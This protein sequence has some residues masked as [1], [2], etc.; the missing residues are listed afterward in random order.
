MQ[1][2][3]DLESMK[4]F[5][6]NRLKYTYKLDDFAAIHVS[7]VKTLSPTDEFTFPNF[8]FFPEKF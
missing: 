3:F 2:T 6:W 4:H 1:E 8:F 5:K 7:V